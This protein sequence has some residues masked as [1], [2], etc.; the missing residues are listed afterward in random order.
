MTLFLGILAMLPFTLV[1]IA[2]IAMHWKEVG[3]FILGMVVMVGFLFTIGGIIY[4]FSWGL[5]VVLLELLDKPITPAANVAP[6]S[7]LSGN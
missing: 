4:S 5:N 3:E 6:V 1:V 7:S 2:I